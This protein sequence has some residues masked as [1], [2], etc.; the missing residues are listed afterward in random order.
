MKTTIIRVNLKQLWN[1][2]YSI[3]VNQLV[4]IITKYQPELLHLK[5][6]FEKLIAF[7]P[8]LVKI[9]AQELSN[10]LSIQLYDLDV[11]RD[12]LINYIIKQVNNMSKL[13]LPTIAPHVVV[14][15]R[16]LDIH[17]RD[18]AT[19]NYNAET[20]RLNNLLADYHAKTDVKNAVIAL[21]L[22]LIF[23]QLELINTS[24]ANLFL[25]RTEDIASVE[26][27]NART[28]RKECDKAILDFIEGFEFCST[29][30][31][32]LDYQTPAKE[33]ND[34]INYY[35]SQLK[36]R[37]TRRVNGKEVHTEDPIVT[38]Q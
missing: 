9:K 17:G 35:K 31:D 23:E 3:F 4:S 7:L 33:M 19:A 25:Q 29:E 27:V 21:N 2:E 13:N 14:L 15:N 10:A 18:I 16:F 5:K 36:A 6:V 11:E 24:F 8:D 37:A 20:Q 28:I 32:T 1:S 12:T 22:L 26:K 34:L 30:Y 38:P